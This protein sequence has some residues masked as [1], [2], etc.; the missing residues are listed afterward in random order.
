MNRR[1]FLKSAAVAAA[2]VP[3]HALIARAETLGRSG[4]V[5]GL[6][7]AGYGALIDAV[8]ETTGLPLLKLPEGFR[9]ASFGWAGD[10]MAD[11]RVTPGKHDGMA[12]FDAGAGRVRLVRNHETDAGTPF[13]RVAYDPNASGGTTTL[14]FDT[15]QGRFISASGSLSGTLRNCAGGPTPWGTWLTCEETNAFTTLPHGYVFEVPADGV[16]NPVPLREMG[17]FS[18]EALAVD[19][20]TGY[21]YETEDQGTTITSLF[22]GSNKSGFYRF[23]PNVNGQLSAGGRLFM[24]K[25]KGRSKQDLG[26]S[27]AHG[28]TFDVEWVPIAR[29]ENPDRSAPEDF[30]WNQGRAQGAATFARLEGCWYGNDRKVYI[31]ATNG[32]R[33]EGQIWVYDPAAETI[34]LLFESPGKHVLNRPD[35]LTVSPRGGLVLCEDGGGDEFLHGL[36]VDGELF[37]F[38]LNN[39]KLRGE[40]NGLTGDFTS[41]EWAGPCFSPDGKWLFANLLDPGITVAITGPWQAGAL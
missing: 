17:R 31:V 29:A 14:E 12:A 20:V 41:S 30:V 21:I 36:T 22:G 28:T 7:T 25:V 9:Y 33:G 3:F 19:P 24:L 1:S 11:G 23:V 40:R 26:N 32:G 37:P 18:H 2:A 5:R 39:V 34:S 15:A 16:G 4:S 8:D 38:A 10:V 35:H 13:S 6:R 27:Y